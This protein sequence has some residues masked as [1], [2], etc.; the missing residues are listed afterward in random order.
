MIFLVEATE[1][2]ADSR[3]CSAP[4]LS[5]ATPGIDME[6]KSNIVRTPRGFEDTVRR[7]A[8]LGNHIFAIRLD[9]DITCA[10]YASVDDE[11]RVCMRVHGHWQLT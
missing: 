2:N 3:I 6:G 11:A 8:A 7:Q 9:G 10:P 1:T 4:R 5:G